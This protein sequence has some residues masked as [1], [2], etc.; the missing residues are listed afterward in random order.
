MIAQSKIPVPSIKKGG[1]QDLPPL[2]QKMLA[3]LVKSDKQPEKLLDKSSDAEK[4]NLPVGALM[5]S[6]VEGTRDLNKI[7][8]VIFIHSFTKN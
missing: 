3:P 1:L 6:V 5:K 8:L 7:G 4:Q 2:P